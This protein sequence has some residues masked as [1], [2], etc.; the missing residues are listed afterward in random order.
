MENPVKVKM[1]DDNDKSALILSS[2]EKSK[3]SLL[4]SILGSEYRTQCPL[5]AFFVR[6]VSLTECNGSS[7]KFPD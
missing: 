4:M 6:K 3:F 7:P 5:S 1:E 2:T